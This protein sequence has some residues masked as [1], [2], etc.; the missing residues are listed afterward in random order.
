MVSLQ[1]KQLFVD[2]QY[3]FSIKKKYILILEIRK[4]KY[5]LINFATFGIPKTS[6]PPLPSK[7]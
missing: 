7:I 6:V 3:F 5:V 1:K 2:F 4:H